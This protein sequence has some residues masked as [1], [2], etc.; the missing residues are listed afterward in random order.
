M[1]QIARQLGT[2]ESSVQAVISMNMPQEERRALAMLR[3]SASKIGAK[4]PVFGKFAAQHPNW[5]RICSDQ[6]GYMT[7]IRERKRVFVHHEVML[8]ALDLSKLPEG[9][10]IHHIDGNGE[11]NDLNI[12]ALVTKKGHSTI[13]ALQRRGGKEYRLRQLKLVEAMKYLT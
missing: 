1:K 11:N 9:L 3:Y 6:K 13:H 10:E 8:K 2:T 7:I 12:L 5:K 4:N